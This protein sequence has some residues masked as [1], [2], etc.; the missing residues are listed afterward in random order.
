M[1]TF[2]VFLIVIIVEF[3]QKIDILKIFFLRWKGW[4]YLICSQGLFGYWTLD[5]VRIAI[6]IFFIMIK[7]STVVFIGDKLISNK[8]IPFREDIEPILMNIN[9]H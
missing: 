7:K 2:Y 8:N 5:E 9:E 6:I 3:N 1:V 4:V